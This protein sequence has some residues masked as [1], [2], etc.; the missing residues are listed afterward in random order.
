MNSKVVKCVNPGCPMDGKEKVVHP[1]S[2]GQ[3]VFARFTAVCGS[4]ESEMQVLR[5]I[6]GRSVSLGQQFVKDL[7]D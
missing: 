5:Q 6:A 2:L 3:N 7:E 1:L 4:C